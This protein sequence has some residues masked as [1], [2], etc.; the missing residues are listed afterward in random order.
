MAT[1]PNLPYVLQTQ[2]FTG[3][4]GSTPYKPATPEQAAT[5]QNIYNDKSVTTVPRTVS[6]NATALKSILMVH[7]TTVCIQQVGSHQLIFM[8][9]R[10]CKRLQRAS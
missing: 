1:V 2:G 3:A 7:I 8:S 4:T 9:C 5:L 10:N 6:P